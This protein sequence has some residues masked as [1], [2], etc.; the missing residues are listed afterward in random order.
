VLDNAHDEAQV[1][2]LLP[3]SSTCAVLVTSRQRLVALEGANFVDLPLM[4]EQ[5]ALELL[6]K[7]ISPQRAKAEQGEAKAIIHLCG[8]LP[9]A[10]RIAG[11]TLNKRSW[12][13]KPLKDYAHQLTD[14]HQQLTALQLENL[15]ENLDV[16]ASFNLSYRELDEADAQMFRLLGIL[17]GIDFG[18]EIIPV[19]LDE[20]IS[21]AEKRIERLEDA[22]LLNRLN[23]DRFQF[24][25]LV[26]TFAQ[27][28]LARIE[29]NEV[30]NEVKQRVAKRYLENAQL[31]NFALDPNFRSLMAEDLIDSDEQPIEIIKKYLLTKALNWFEIE[32]A[33]LIQPF[34]LSFSTV[35]AFRKPVIQELSMNQTGGN[36][37]D[38]GYRF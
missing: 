17:E 11:G 19:I 29:P 25:D 18:K 14:E 9:L 28:K 33:N 36:F 5:E 22:Q 20:E 24:H 2:P 38:L 31:W 16:R 1:R 30:Q 34:P 32:R 12:E 13:Y 3:G 10:I 35:T 37:D 26:R 23:E 6:Q 27:E 21:I 8:R 7:M 15:P 4:P